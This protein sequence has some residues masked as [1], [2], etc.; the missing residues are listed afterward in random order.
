MLQARAKLEQAHAL[1]RELA[2]ARARI[3]ELEARQAMMHV[4]SAEPPATHGHPAHF[5]ARSPN[6]GGGTVR[7]GNNAPT[8]GDQAS[9]AFVTPARR[10]TSGCAQ[11][12]VH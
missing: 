12:Y 10:P 7:A 4:T 5:S 11:R 8:V 1:D 3:R 6:H 2:E 9:L